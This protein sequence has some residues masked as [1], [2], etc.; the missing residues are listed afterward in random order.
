MVSIQDWEVGLDTRKYR[1]KE[2]FFSETD[3]T[4]RKTT[5]VRRLYNQKAGGNQ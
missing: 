5:K 1:E 3:T 4:F 2:T